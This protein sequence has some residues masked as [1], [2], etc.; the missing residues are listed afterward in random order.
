MEASFEWNVD[1]QQQQQSFEKMNKE[2]R[3]TTIA[4]MHFYLVEACAIFHDA[5]SSNT[6]RMCMML[7]CDMHSKLIDWKKL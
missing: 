5:R 3:T 2:N 7:K 6:N 4:D 1:Q